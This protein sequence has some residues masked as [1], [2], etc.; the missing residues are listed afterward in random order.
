MTNEPR[1]LRDVIDI[2]LDLPIPSNRKLA[3]AIHDDLYI[4]FLLLIERDVDR[5]SVV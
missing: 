4:V 2:P 3:E 5:K 1:L